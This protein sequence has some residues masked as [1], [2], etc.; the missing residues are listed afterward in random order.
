LIGRVA[1]TA[2]VAVS[3][4]ACAAFS[5]G[6]GPRYS[7]VGLASWYGREFQQARTASGERYDRRAMTAAHRTLPF[8]TVV[9]VTDLE[10]GRMVKVRINDRGPFVKGRIID[11]SE[12]AAR[13]LG[14][15][16]DGVAKVRVEAFDSDQPSS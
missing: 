13:A 1:A 8:Q 14:I 5:S 16:Q 4:A 6:E 11:L 7:Q 9:R 2:L 15:A 10:T 3:L 12:R